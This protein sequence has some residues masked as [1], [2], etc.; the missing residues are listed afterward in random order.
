MATPRVF[1]SSTYYDLQHVRNDIASFLKSIGYEA[2][3]HDS[4][5]VTYS[6][7]VS[8]E[9]SCYNELSTC[10][11]VVCVI[12]GKFGSQAESGNSITMEELNTAIKNRKKLFVYIQESVYSENNTY[13]ANKDIA[14]TPYYVDDI[15]VHKYI[16]DLKET[17]RNHPIIP[18]STVQDIVDNL[19]SQLAGLFQYLLSR[20]ATLTESETYNDL[21]STSDDI[22]AAVAGFKSEAD[23]F[24]RK[25]SGT[26]LYGLG[27]I[28]YLLELLGIESYDVFI[29][30]I[31]SLCA[32]MKDIGYENT[33]DDSPFADYTFS[34]TVGGHINILTFSESLV[35]INGNIIENR[36]RREL[37]TKITLTTQMIE[38]P[39]DDGLP[40]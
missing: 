26:K 18:F 25:F 30:T 36:N 23:S 33:S 3:L 13:L 1:I 35:E 31:E 21:K 6:Q 27:P 38:V 5:N 32:F 37:S 8:L 39:V 20:E 34:Q 9:Q 12:G 28:K 19:R 29:P 24:F 4:G 7:D 10:D 11:I 40:F 15:R 2:V 16:A 22:K 14:F 17:V